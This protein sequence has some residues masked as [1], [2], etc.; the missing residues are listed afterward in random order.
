MTPKVTSRKTDNRPFNSDYY[1]QKRA[2]YQLLYR[3]VKAAIQDYKKS[4]DSEALLADHIAWYISEEL[5]ED[6]ELAIAKKPLQKEVMG[7][8]VN[9]P[10][11]GCLSIIA[12]FFGLII[13]GVFFA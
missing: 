13:Y 6:L 8:E 4:S 2:N 7:V 12:I 5:P 10:Q 9:W 3:L 11:I 1:N